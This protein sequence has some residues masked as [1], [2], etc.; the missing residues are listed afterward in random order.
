[1]SKR[2][3]S[4]SES[5]SSSNKKRHVNDDAILTDKRYDELYKYYCKPWDQINAESGGGTLRKKRQ[6]PRMKLMKRV[7]KEMM[8]A[9]KLI[10]K[11][12]KLR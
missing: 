12:N 11:Q 10:G 8:K 9:R 1:M 4:S 6:P 7:Y 5:S 3:N 2:K